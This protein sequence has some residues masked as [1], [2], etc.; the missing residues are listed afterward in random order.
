[1]R[2]TGELAHIDVTPT[3][4]QVMLKKVVVV[5]AVCLALGCTSAQA[6]D[7]A[8][9]QPAT[10]SSTEGGRSEFEPT[11]ANDGNSST[12]WSSEFVDHQWWQVDLGSNQSI[13]RVELNWE[14][15]YARQYRIQT[16]TATRD[17]WSTAAW[18]SISSPGLKTHT[19]ATRR[20]RYVRIQGDV[21]ATPWGISLWD[22]RVCNITCSGP[23]PPPPDADGDGAPDSSDQCPDEAG[24]A[25][26]NGCPVP[27]PPNDTDGDGV[28]DN[29]DQCPNQPGPASTNGCPMP[30]P[31]EEPAPIAGEGYRK[32]WSDEFDF[33]NTGVWR[34]GLWHEGHT[35]TAEEASVSNGTLKLVSKR[36]NG[37][38]NTTISTDRSATSY[39]SWKEGY[40][41]GRVRMN[42]GPGNFPAFWL[43]SRVH[44]FNTSYPQP[45]CGQPTC[46]AAEIDLFEGQ[47][48]QPT[49]FYGSIH[50]NSAS[51]YGRNQINS[52]N[53]QNLGRDLYGMIWHTISIKWSSTTVSWYLDEQL[54]HSAPVFDSTPQ[55]MFMLLQSKVGGWATGNVPGPTTPDDL[56]MEY[57]WVRVWQR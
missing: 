23:A 14:V 16:R 38:R 17:S 20:A 13:N 8:L 39:K 2:L 26:N 7:F 50:R 19:F 37:Y 24:P 42:N 56:T 55:D 41:E 51:A 34:L 9:N 53:Y 54:I 11:N 18:G 49:V 6:Q 40:F 43:L 30:P 28:P 3:A 57:D 21:R 47:G 46:L 1:M 22:L 48:T 10:A 33:L 44:R 32:V 25:S 45:A 52:N 27:P 35:P 31:S 15:A 29:Q 5:A 4:R 36:R 12:R